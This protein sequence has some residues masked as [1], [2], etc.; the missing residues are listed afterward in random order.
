MSSDGN[1]DPARMSAAERDGDE[2]IGSALTTGR[3]A[4]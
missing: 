4:K 3:T 2:N 1:E